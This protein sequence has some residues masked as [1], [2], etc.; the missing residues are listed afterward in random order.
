M[1]EYGTQQNPPS[2]DP[3]QLPYGEPPAP[4]Q[5]PQAP[6]APQLSPE[7]EQA[8][9]LYSTYRLHVG[10]LTEAGV[11]MPQWEGLSIPMR[12][13]WTA[14]QQAASGGSPPAP[15]SQASQD[16]PPEPAPPPAPTF[17][18]P[19][20]LTREDLEHRSETTLRDLCTQRGVAVPTT[21]TKEELIEALLAQQEQ[22]EQQ[23]P[24]EPTP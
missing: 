21:A 14:V 5:P 12:N 24:Q 20:P 8:R 4:T 23:G 17:A 13:A 1:A 3:S 10:G 7:E 9:Q 15:E 19:P 2:P 6:Q 11:G 18:D 16:P 22:Q